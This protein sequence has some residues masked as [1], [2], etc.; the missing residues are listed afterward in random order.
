MPH[1][2]Q[3][4]PRTSSP[5]SSASFAPPILSSASF[6]CSLE[7][8]DGQCGRLLCWPLAAAGRGGERG[9]PVLCGVAPVLPRSRQAR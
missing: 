4:H 1:H 9:G 2:D 5:S 6:S 3:H 7:V 8:R